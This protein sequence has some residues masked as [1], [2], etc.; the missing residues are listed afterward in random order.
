[1]SDVDVMRS[2][3]GIMKRPA[4]KM[5]GDDDDDDVSN[6]T[7]REYRA[8]DRLSYSSL[9]EFIED[10]M[11]Y[12]EVHEVRTKKSHKSSNEMRFG[13]LVETLLW[14]SEEG[15]HRLFCESVLPKPPG[16]M[17]E[18]ID[19]L[20]ELRLACLDD[21]GNLTREPVALIG[22]AY[23]Y[24]AFDASGNQVKFKRQ[25]LEDILKG[26]P[27]SDADRYLGQLISNENKYLVDL[28]EKTYAEKCKEQLQNH[29]VS[30]E[31]VTRKSDDRY[32]VYHQLVILFTYK[33]I[34]M[35]SRLDM[36]V[37][38]HQLR[39]IFIYDLKT[40]F[41]VEEFNFSY[42][43]YRYYIQA[44]L[45]WFAA[46]KW[47]MRNGYEHYP[48]NYMEFIVADSKAKLAPLIR[49]M[50]RRNM[51][52]A[53]DGFT[54]QGK[55]YVGVDTAIEAL[56]WHRQSSVWSMS[57]YNYERHGIGSIKV[58]EDE[59]SEINQHNVVPAAGIRVV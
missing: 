57:R 9:K 23:N 34:K 46:N 40:T 20:Q 27:D 10:R 17:G 4:M 26:W 44:Y 32:D 3:I 49:K 18:L 28:K 24:V 1:M 15:Y 7:E 13:V 2:G 51:L 47:A 16:Q 42:R 29:W 22:E 50:K 30:R 55:R 39:Q 43:K 37:V 31:L 38:D 8:I 48:V 59:K 5:V 33:G 25:K 36:L 35:K 41:D 12:Y 58:Y 14:D 45:Y 19:K 54:Y 53:R 6:L 56:K 21:N 11:D 52:N